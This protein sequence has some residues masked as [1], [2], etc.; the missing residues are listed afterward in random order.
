MSL[1]A[2]TPRISMFTTALLRFGDAI[3][4]DAMIAELLE[5]TAKEHKKKGL[6]GGGAHKKAPS[7]KA[8]GAVAASNQPH[9]LELQ[10]EPPVSPEDLAYS[11]TSPLASSQSQAENDSDRPPPPPYFAVDSSTSTATVT[12]TEAAA[13]P[14]RPPR[15]ARPDRT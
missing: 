15:P 4:T 9:A 14:V 11:Y 1:M 8:N 2:E 10:S 7:A 13:R 6:F 3:F 5:A 12:A